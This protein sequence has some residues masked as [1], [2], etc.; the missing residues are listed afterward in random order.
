MRTQIRLSALPLAA[1]LILA[2]LVATGCVNTPPPSVPA[3]DETRQIQSAYQPAPSPIRIEACACVGFSG[4]T[5]LPDT[6]GAI[7][8]RTVKDVLSSDIAASG[9]FARIADVTSADYLVNLDFKDPRESDRHITV[10]LFVIE[11]ATGAQVF[12]DTREVS[13]EDPG[14]GRSTRWIDALPGLMAALKADLAA[15]LGPKVR[16]RNEQAAR[17][18]SALLGASLS[19]LLASSDKNVTLARVRNRAIIAAKTSQ[20]PAVLRDWKS[21]QLSGLA[22]KIE[23]TILDLDHEGEVAKD[24]AQQAVAGSAVSATGLEQLRGLA[25]CYRERIEL[26]KP[27][28]GALREEIAN[29]G[30]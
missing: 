1:A 15:D 28:L 18:E 25:I 22:V 20:L 12:S 7:Y 17:D 21:D 4:S 9:L 19:D 10:S 2:L 24:R 30:R 6:D 13:L 23:Q 16:A 8:L 11:T 14:T 26:L 27:I 5:G 29:R 3:P